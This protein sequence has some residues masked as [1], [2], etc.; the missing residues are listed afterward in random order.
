MQLPETNTSF[1]AFKNS[2]TELTSKQEIKYWAEGQPDPTE[3]VGDKKIYLY[4]AG[5]FIAEPIHGS[6]YTIIK[7]EI[8][9]GSV[10]GL[11]AYLY[12]YYE[13]KAQLNNFKRHIHVYTDP[14]RMMEWAM[15]NGYEPVHFAKANRLYVYV[16]SE[17]FICFMCQKGAGFTLTNGRQTIA[18]QDELEEILSER[19]HI[20]RLVKGPDA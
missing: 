1:L 11:E 15:K 5:F 19:Y 14:K 13:K 2:R 12:P 16:E 18:N 4:D 3:F 9:A 20:S 6:A 17:F 7:G 10:A 8:H